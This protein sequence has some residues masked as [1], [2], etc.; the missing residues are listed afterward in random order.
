VAVTAIAP[1]KVRGVT[2]Q[3][4]VLAV[5][6]LTVLG[7]VLRF[8]TLGD[9][10]FWYDEALTVNLVHSSFGHMLAGVN[11]EEATPPL[12][13]CLAW[14]W[15]HLFGTG[16]VGL[17]SLSAVAGTIA[18]PVAYSAART[19]IGRRTGLIT[20]LLV[21]LSPALIWYSQEARSYALLT[22]LCALSLLFFAR[23]RERPSRSNFIGW[24][25]AS[26]LALTTHYFAV[27]LIAP[28]AVW[29]LVAT[30]NRRAAVA[31]SAAVAA[32][33]IALAPLAIH[34]RVH[35]GTEWIGFTP[36]QTRLKGV[37]TFFV[38]GTESVGLR[39]SWVLA[40]LGLAAV[41]ALL[42]RRADR[43]T[44]RRALEVFGLGC[45]AIALPLFLAA[46]GYDY[47]HGRNL[48]PAWLPLCIVVAAA[49]GAR[50]AGALAAIGLVAVCAVLIDFDLRVQTTANWQRDDWRG[51]ADTLG[52]AHQDRVLVVA[53][54]WQARALMVYLPRMG[55]AQST[56]SVSEIDV[57]AYNGPVPAPQR[58]QIPTPGLPFRLTERRS[59]QKFT[60]MR[61][62]A[63]RPT[64]V[65]ARSLTGTRLD[66]SL[67]YPLV[68]RAA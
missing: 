15:G 41:A 6:G 54:G 3:S 66:R 53:P 52:V 39:P 61:Y 32:T 1:T 33:G 46:A 30:A 47:V 48:L 16:E 57:I 23:A 4:T 9:Q 44:R 45:A 5:A 65:S 62:R 58:P 37:A 26:A 50:R 38:T 56:E 35:G 40:G 12:Y 64:A 28:E 17:R 24:A 10:S 55:A 19:M 25:L 60:V 20:A 34:Q 13:F 42:L 27:F 8:W 67:T 21:A 7:G 11:A 49:L 2:V 43:R 14:V 31:A 68:Q 51:V 29:L 22:L 63:Q 36:L 59:M 18:V